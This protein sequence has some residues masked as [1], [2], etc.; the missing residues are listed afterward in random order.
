[1]SRL[2]ALLATTFALTPPASGDEMQPILRLDTLRDE[3]V[4]RSVVLYANDIDPNSSS[5]DDRYRLTVNDAEVTVPAAL[6]E[7][8]DRERRGYSY[9]HFTKGIRNEEAAFRCMMAGPALG[10]VLSVLYLTHD[11]TKIVASE[12]RPVLSR[13]ENCLFITQLRPV[14]DEARVEAAAAMAALRT[15]SGILA[16]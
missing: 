1:M 16:E 9:D 2:L 4:E 6:L 3:R 12:M 14:S 15:I 7:R 8:L 11:D 10:H 13:P 5:V